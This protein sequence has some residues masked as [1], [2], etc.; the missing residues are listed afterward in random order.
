M[1]K[2]IISPHI[3]DEVLGCGGILDENTLIIECGIDE[4]RDIPG[5]GVVTH[6]SRESEL[7]AVC[8][9]CKVEYIILE[10]E[11]NNYN[12]RDLIPELE[13]A[14][15]YTKPDEVYIPYPSY[16]QDHREVYE[17]AFTALRP[18]DVNHFVKK[19]FIYEQPHVFLWD[20]NHGDIKVNYYVEISIEKKLRLYNLIPSQVRAFRSPDTVKAL[21]ELRGKQSG[22]KYAEAYQILRYVK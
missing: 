15:N 7:K 3:D 14:I 1:K 20:Y 16:N 17:A 21:A 2:L 6:D 11:V 5:W 10:N 22:Y 18:H 12:L 13:N 9:D 19:V 8:E 4:K